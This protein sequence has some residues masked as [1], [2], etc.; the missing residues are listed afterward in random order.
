[1]FG[2]NNTLQFS[3]R[4]PNGATGTFGATYVPSVDLFS[5]T[6]TSGDGVVPGVNF[7]WAF[8]LSGNVMRLSCG[9]GTGTGS[10]DN[11]AFVL[12]HGLRNGFDFDGDGT[13]EH[14]TWTITLTKQS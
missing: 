10:S 11:R 6:F 2:S 13:L 9:P 12:D 4:Q 8:S 3:L 14:A 5:V 1:M 7:A